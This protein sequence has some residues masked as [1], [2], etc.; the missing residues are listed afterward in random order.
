MGKRSHPKPRLTRQ[1]WIDA[2]IRQ[3]VEAGIGAVSVEQLATR[4]GVTRGSFYHHFA[5][6][7]HLLRAML[8]YWARRWTYEVRE[9]INALGLDASTTLFALMKAIRNNRAADY[10]APFRAWA[11]HDPFAR[12]VVEQ[13]DQARLDQIQ[14][15]FAGLG[16]T[17]LDLE[18]RARLFLYFEMGAPTMF[19][20]PTP[21]RDEEL[22]EERHRFLT[23][24]HVG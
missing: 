8:E 11:P 14:G 19:A 12:A 13:V 23:T 21:E 7:E 24:A 2:A 20:G 22:L 3:L 15:L 18:N 16:F 5:D 6:R 9:Q 1:G 17:G 10:D 4:L